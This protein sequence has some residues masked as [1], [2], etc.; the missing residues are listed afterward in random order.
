M[1]MMALLCQELLR[2]AGHPMHLTHIASHLP[3]LSRPWPPLCPGHPIP[4]H[5]SHP[6][7]PHPWPP[8][9]P[10]QP[11]PPSCITQPHR[12]ILTALTLWLCRTASHHVAL[13]VCITPQGENIH[14]S[15]EN[16]SPASRHSY[17]MHLVE[18]EPWARWSPDNWAHRDPAHPWQPLYECK[19][20]GV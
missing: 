14:Y 7:P 6:Y 16:R 17:S 18:G 4:G 9:S 3:H 15:C 12:C 5:P 8:Q 1:D 19:G 2:P 20:A 11:T 13:C 10:K